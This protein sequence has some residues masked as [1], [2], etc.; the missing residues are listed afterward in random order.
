MSRLLLELELDA[1]C[2]EFLI[3]RGCR[4]HQPVI[5]NEAGLPRSWEKILD[6]PAPD[7]PDYSGDGDEP[8]AA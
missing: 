7:E 3:A 4:I 8:E 6:Q 5:L 2:D 1:L